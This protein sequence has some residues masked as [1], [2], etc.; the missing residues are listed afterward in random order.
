MVGMTLAYGSIWEALLGSSDPNS[1]NLQNIKK[2]M[3][4]DTGGV[5]TS[6]QETITDTKT[7]SIIF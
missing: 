1:I 2:I 3:M 4:A 5:N 7:F 6:V